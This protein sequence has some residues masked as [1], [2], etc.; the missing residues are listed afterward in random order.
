MP[1]ADSQETI[2]EIIILV[3]LGALFFLWLAGKAS[4]NAE[5]MDADCKAHASDA[6]AMRRIAK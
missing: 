5:D 2:M 6:E 1:A 3:G 4:G